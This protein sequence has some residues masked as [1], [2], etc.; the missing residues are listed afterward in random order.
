MKLISMT[1]YVL[2]SSYGDTGMFEKGG[3]AEALKGINNYAKFL[4][5]PLKLEMFVPIDD[6]GNVL[7]YPEKS[8]KLAEGVI[9]YS[10]YNLWCER[11]KKFLDKVLF[12][13]FEFNGAYLINHNDNRTVILSLEPNKKLK[14]VVDTGNNTSCMK[15]VSNIEL[16]TNCDIELTE[17]AIKQL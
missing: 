10:K 17:N 12:K 5:Q 11:N 3:I 14:L 2:E 8:E 1:D 4:S 13:G 6:E 15:E 16:L 9:S 7:E